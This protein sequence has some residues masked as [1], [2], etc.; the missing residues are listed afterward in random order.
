VE[1]SSAKFNYAFNVIPKN[2]PAIFAK[3]SVVFIST[4][5]KKEKTYLK[6]SKDREI[7]TESLY[8]FI[9]Y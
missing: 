4:V 1:I 3:Q 2:Q 6:E 9:L 5:K 7:N 8:W